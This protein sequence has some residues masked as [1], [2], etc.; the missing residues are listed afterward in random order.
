MSANVRWCSEGQ[1]IEDV[2]AQMANMQVRRMPVVDEDQ[3]LI[4]IVS[5]GDL[6]TRAVTET[7]ST[8]RKISSSA[9]AY[10][11]AF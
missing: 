4:G 10:H 5:L 1:N 11:A 7:G 2:L 8:L 3:N 9:P 6:A